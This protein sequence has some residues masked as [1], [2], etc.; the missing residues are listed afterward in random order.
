MT[1]A[2][3]D[4]AHIDTLLIN[5]LLQIYAGTYYNTVIFILRHLLFTRLIQKNGKGEYLYDDK[6]LD[7]L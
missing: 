3:V 1:D 4:G 5:I 7:R 2:D 6:A